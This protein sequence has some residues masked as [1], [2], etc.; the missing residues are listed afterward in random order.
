MSL[1]CGCSYN[2]GCLPFWAS[3][4]SNLTQYLTRFDKCGYTFS[5]QLYMLPLCK[6]MELQETI[7]L[8]LLNFTKVA[9]C[10]F[11]WNLN[12]KKNT[13]C[14]L[15]RGTFSLISQMRLSDFISPNIEIVSAH[16]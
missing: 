9:T 13:L 2:K 11:S 16:K 12:L 3:K 15:N 8:E 14:L 1:Q 6:I 5:G 7:S 10:T 4:C